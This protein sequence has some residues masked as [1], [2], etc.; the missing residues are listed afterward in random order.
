MVVQST[1][2]TDPPRVSPQRRNPQPNK[3]KPGRQV[4]ANAGLPLPTRCGRWARRHKRWSAVILVFVLLTPAWVSMAGAATN[5]TLGTTLSG[6]LAEWVRNHGGGSFVVSLEDFWYSHHHAPVGGTPPK[7][8]IPAAKSS[9]TTTSVSQLALPTPSPLQPIVT[10]PP[11]SGEGQWSPAGR[12]VDGIPAVYETYIR[13]DPVYS[14]VVTAV[15]WMDTKL[16]STTLY[17]GSQVPG[18]GPFANTAPIQ[19]AAAQTL[20]AAFNAGFRMQD[21]EGGYYTD[22]RVEIPLRN[23]GASFVVYSN[24]TCNIGVWGRDFTMSPNIVSVRQNLV[25][26][27][28]NG[29]PAPDLL[30]TDTHVW[31]ATLGNKDQVWRSAVGITANGALVYV[32]GPNLNITD[33]AAVLVRAGAVRAMELDINTDWV[34]FA[35]YNPGPND[36]GVASPSNGTD[37]LANMASGPDRYFHSW[38]A[39]DFFTMSA[40]PSPIISVPTP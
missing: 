3:Q 14:S 4:S 18:G 40:R 2:M 8:A 29:Q 30:S 28:D 32:A 23:G 37:L 6:R 26:L 19:G 11:I 1:G 39:R 36:N 10:S 22:G 24:G 20:V 15:A 31:G 16:L 5:P 7:G 21:A 27:V 13:P 35:T 17:S 33:L 38:W 34:N 12:T 25:L 9:P